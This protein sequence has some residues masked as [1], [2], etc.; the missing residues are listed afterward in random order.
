MGGYENLPHP[1]PADQMEY[2][3][4]GRALLGGYSGQAGSVP[5]TIT[6]GQEVTYTFNYTVPSGSNRSKMHAIAVLI[7]QSNGEIVNGEVKSMDET[8]GV[9]DINII[10]LRIY[11]NPATDNLNVRFEAKGDYTITLTDMLGRVLSTKPYNGL[12]GLQNVN[13]PVN[14]L[15]EGNYIV[16]VATQGASYSQIV[17]VKK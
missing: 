3:H 13:V 16:S 1:V 17:A 7:D 6:N 10:Q 4:T 11:P 12:Y 8:L 5:T 14:H 15:S 2:D 9:A